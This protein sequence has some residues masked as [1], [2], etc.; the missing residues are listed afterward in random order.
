MDHK[1]P[2]LR[3]RAKGKA[4]LTDND[5]VRP[6]SVARPDNIRQPH[7][8]MHELTPEIGKHLAEGQST[9]SS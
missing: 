1:K 5:A 7:S 9:K 4:A 2:D 8:D 3:D 6:G